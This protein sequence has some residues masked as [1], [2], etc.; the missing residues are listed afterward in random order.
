MNPRSGLITAAALSV[1]ILLAIAS[2]AG[3]PLFT[4]PS[5]TAEGDQAFA[6]FG[7]SVTGAGDVDNDGYDDV[8]VGAPL[9]DGSL[10]DEGQAF[11]FLGDAGGLAL[12]PVWNPTGGQSFANF[13]WSV[14][15]AGDVNN[16]GYDDVIV[17][18]PFYFNGQVREGR[19]FV[20]HG[21]I[22]GPSPGAAWTAEG[23]QD[24]ANFGWLVAS[25]GDVNNDGFADVIVG[26]PLYSNGEVEEGRAYVYHGGS[27]GLAAG[28]AW[29][30]E[31]DQASANFGWSVASAGDVNGDGFDDVIVGVPQYTN[32]ETEEGRAYV[33]LG[34]SGGLA[35]TPAWT[36]EGDQAFA[37]LGYSVAGA[38]DV[39]NDG[40]ADVIVG[41][42]RYDNGESNEGRAYVYLGSG[43]GL[44]TTPTWTAEG[45]Q[46]FASF[47][48]SVA[49][50]GD[51]NRDGFADVIVGAYQYDGGELNEGRA[52][53]YLG[54][55]SG[56]DTTPIWTGESDQ[57]LAWFGYSVAGAGDVN[58]SGYSDI[59]I[60]V[61]HA[62]N[63]ESNEGQALVFHG[64]DVVPVSLQS[65]ESHWD[66]T[67][68]VV[69]WTLLDV[70]TGVSFE[71]LRSGAP[72]GRYQRIEEP[73][74]VRSGDR[75]VFRDRTAEPGKTYKY[76]V[77]IIEDGT[78]VTFFETSV[79]VPASSFAL[80]Q[81]YPNPFNPETRI[82]F[83]VDR[84]GPVTLRVYDV[85]G[86]LVRTLIDRTMAAKSHTA[87]WNGTNNDGLRAGSGTY[88]FRLTSGKRTL[89]RKAVLLK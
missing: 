61:P 86:A 50:A 60:G 16:D 3:G 46:A 88:F 17:G 20:Y 29:L 75:F 2:R 72:E 9:L 55:G 67:D 69:T 66:G 80:G 64:F 40:F 58:Q 62:A 25:A 26:A 49:G 19:A 82:R 39:D 6:T 87:I 21:G 53:V 74:I 11:V 7:W 8:I 31:G 79:S 47:G 71:V 34:G 52:Y 73:E 76:G 28:H 44:A 24:E 4:I 81:N 30:A 14:A 22:G 51:A 68:V 78:P 56:L 43:S 83:T 27:L 36:V 45:D 59:I 65:F 48:R 13:G 12:L 41:A 85:S 89:V 38:G 33:Y 54:S 42:Y 84:A 1:V 70:T 10:P 5:W 63:P 77:T 18:A 15:G 35:T 37:N 23:N 32:G 57:N